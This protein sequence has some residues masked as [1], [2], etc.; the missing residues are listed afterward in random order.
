VAVVTVSALLSP[1]IAHATTPGE[2]G[3]I[4]FRRFLDV[5]LNWGALFSIEPDGTV[6]RQIT[7]LRRKVGDDHP[8]VSPDG[9]WIVY[10]K[11]W[12]LREGHPG[13]IFRI[14]MNGTE[15][16]NLTG[17]TCRPE[18]IACGTSPPPGHRTAGGSHSPG[19]SPLRPANGRSTCS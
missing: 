2:N 3:R 17:D 9:R 1:A 7:H 5:A 4:V 13:A 8:D 16:K 6:E 10:D 18:E 19:H 15:R 14:R 11:K 12:Q